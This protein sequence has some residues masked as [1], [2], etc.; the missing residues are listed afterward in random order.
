MRIGDVARET[1]LSIDAIRFYERR[2]LLRE[3]ERTEGGFRLYGEEDLVSLRFIRRMQKLGFS[4][5]E[6][7]ELLTLRSGES[8]PCAEMKELL[9]AKLDAVRGKQT[10]LRTLELDLK[11]ALQRCKRG[12]RKPSGPARCPVLE[13]P[14]GARRRK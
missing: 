1:G 9:A 7:G 2:R 10:E 12:I 6:I 8:Q 5:V 4:L 3:P 14:K 13:E 11:K